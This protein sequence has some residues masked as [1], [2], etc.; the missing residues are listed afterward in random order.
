MR[1]ACPVTASLVSVTRRWL[2]GPPLAPGASC[3]AGRCAAVATAGGSRWPQPGLRHVCPRRVPRWTRHRVSSHSVSLSSASWGAV[4][5]QPQLG[6]VGARGGARPLQHLHVLPDLPPCRSSLPQGRLHAALLCSAGVTR[7][8][9]AFWQVPEQ[10]G[11]GLRSLKS[12]LVYP[13]P[14][15][16][17]A[18]P[19][20]ETAG[21]CC[22]GEVGEERHASDLTLC[23][24]LCP[25]F[26]T[27]RA[28]GTQEGRRPCWVAVPAP[29]PVAC[30]ALSCR[31]SSGRSSCLWLEMGCEV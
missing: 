26:V 31:F 14:W 2:A 4:G 18:G 11:A 28:V 12:C 6:L 3:T 17:D 1:R 27:P 10:P 13:G 21:P 7:A 29:R 19:R 8:R 30:G 5:T 15:G 24:G 23:R 20:V 22:R 9:R 25:A 16:S